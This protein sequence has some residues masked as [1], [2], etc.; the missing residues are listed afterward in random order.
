MG[1]RASLRGWAKRLAP[2]IYVVLLLAAIIASVWL[3]PN[4]GAAVFLGI[5]AGAIVSFMLSKRARHVTR[6]AVLWAALAVTADAAYAKLND[7]TPVTV[8]G[9]L[10]KVVDA[11]VKLAEPLIKGVGLAGADPRV[12]IGAVAPDF[13][14]ALILSMIFMISLSFELTRNQR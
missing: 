14:W 12:K 10:M 11:V 1:S 2:T 3:L 5:L 4:R 13:V 7:Q 9:A 6:I 8:A